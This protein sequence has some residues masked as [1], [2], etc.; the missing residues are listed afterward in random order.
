MPGVNFS[1]NIFSFL[2]STSFVTIESIDFSGKVE[3]SQNNKFK[4]GD[5]IISTGWRDGEM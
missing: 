2:S 4:P 3:E 5:E 1:L